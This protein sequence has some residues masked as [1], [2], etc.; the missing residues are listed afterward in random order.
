MPWGR[1]KWVSPAIW[2]LNEQ[3]WVAWDDGGEI[4]S[5][6]KIF[7][8]EW[9]LFIWV[10]SPLYELEFFFKG[11]SFSSESDWLRFFWFCWLWNEVRIWIGAGN[12]TGAWAC[13]GA[14]AVT[15]INFVEN[16]FNLLGVLFLE[17][18]PWSIFFWFCPDFIWNNLIIDDEQFFYLSDMRISHGGK[19]PFIWSLNLN[20]GSKDYF[21]ISYGSAV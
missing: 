12:C 4:P 13:I 11:G 6:L 21:T 9:F 1:E 15:Y 7:R 17:L 5:F 20:A 2:Y 18:F 19:W 8:I 10:L 14:W 3:L 16:P